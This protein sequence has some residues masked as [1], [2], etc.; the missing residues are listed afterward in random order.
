MCPLFPALLILI[1][2][3]DRSTLFCSSPD[4]ITSIR[5][6]TAFCNVSGYAIPIPSSF[7]LNKNP[8]TLLLP[9]PNTV[10]AAFMYILLH[11][12]LL[13]VCHVLAMFIKLNWPLFARKVALAGQCKYI[14]A[15]STIL[16]AI[17]PII[18]VGAVFAWNGFSILTYPPLFCFSTERNMIYYLLI[19]PISINLAVGSSLLAVIIYIINK[20]FSLYLTLYS[21]QNIK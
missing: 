7:D 14:H 19:L 4:L 10:G 1:H 20:V 16:L 18:P 5:H 13:W 17:I 2:N 15:A 3:A 11:I 6:P 9:S 12:S 21:V 8:P